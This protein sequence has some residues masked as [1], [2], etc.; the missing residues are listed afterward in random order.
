MGCH[1]AWAYDEHGHYHGGRTEVFCLAEKLFKLHYYDINSSYPFSMTQDM[2]VG[3]MNQSTGDFS[4]EQIA[5]QVAKGYIAF[6]EC[7]VQI[8]DTCSIPPLPVVRDDKLIFPTGVFYGRWDWTELKH[9]THAAVGGKILKT[10]R[11]T[12][13]KGSPIFKEMILMLYAERLRLGKKTA[14]GE[15]RKLLMNAHYGKYIQNPERKKITTHTCGDAFL[16]GERP[17]NPS[18]DFRG[19]D[20]REWPLKFIEEYNES[21]Y[22]L[23]QI[24]SH[25]TSLSREKLWLAAV[26]LESRGFRVY[27]MDTDSLMTDGML[28]SGD[29]LGEWKEEHPGV[30]FAG[31]FPN[32]KSYMLSASPGLVFSGHHEISEETGKRTCEEKCKGCA[33]NIVH[34]KGIA[35]R[36]H[37]K[38]TFETFMRGEGI[39]EMR[40]P[41][42]GV[43]SRNLFS[44]YETKPLEKFKRSTYDKREILGDGRSTRAHFLTLDSTFEFYGEKK[45]TCAKILQSWSEE[46]VAA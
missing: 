18:A 44:E 19:G 21:D 36:K 33:R 35:R 15:A 6:V 23:P 30:L 34:L 28:A 11:I 25:I 32:P 1:H 27:Y 46:R 38:A 20:P 13:F 10:K 4:Y 43:L 26:D 40:P 42:L 9:L 2:P 8:P 3:R 7:V 31:D 24:G 29:E 5:A 14:E 17:T 22:F 12:W 45:M 37:F 39:S 41:K 16:E